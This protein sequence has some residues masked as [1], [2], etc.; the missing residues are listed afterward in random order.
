[1]PNQHVLQR[2]LLYQLTVST[3]SLFNTPFAILQ[4]MLH[5][6][7]DEDLGGIGS[8]GGAADHEGEEGEEDIEA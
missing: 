1:V 6:N 4:S 5:A 7:S 3:A 2:L 8:D